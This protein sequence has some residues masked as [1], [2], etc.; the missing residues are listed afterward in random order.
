MSGIALIPFSTR[1]GDEIGGHIARGL[2]L[3]LSDWLAT[4][5]AEPMVLN[6]AQTEE[7][8]AWRKLV[9][10]SD[11]LTTENVVEFMSDIRGED[12]E[13]PDFRTVISGVIEAIADS[14]LSSG[15]HVAIS[16]TDLAGAFLRGRFACDLM[17]AS[18]GNSIVR[19]FNDVAESLDVK[20]PA[21]YDPL[22]RHIES[23]LNVIVT[24][25][26]T[27]AAEVGAVSRDAEGVYA[28][29]LEALRLDPEFK[30]ARDRLAELTQV[31]VLE[32][33][34]EAT[35]AIKALETAIA[36]AGADWRS[37]RARGHLLLAGGEFGQ[38]AKAF[39]L[40]LSGRHEAPDKADRMQ[41][42]L[43]AG[44]AFNLADRHAEA[45]R[46]LS[47]AMQAENLRVDAIVE[48]AS[49]SASM[50]ETAVAE[51]LWNRAL[52]LEPQSI[53]A[54]LYL[55]RLY[56]SRGEMDEAANQYVEML[57]QPGLPREIF[58]DAAEFFVVNQMHEKALGAAEKY[59][60]EHPG[61]AIAHVLTAS[62]LNAL[63][64][65]KRALKALD[66]A[67]LCVGVDDFH[68]LMVRQ[69]RFAEHPEA[70]KRFRAWAEVCLTGSA[71][72]GEREIRAIIDKFE[73]FWEAHFFLGIALRRQDKFEEAR[74]VLEHLR[75]R[76]PLPGIEKELTGIY[77][78]L[79]EPQKALDYARQALDAAPED[80]TLLTNYAAALLENNE[81]DEANKFASR[82][83]MLMPDD[84]ATAKLSELIKLR[85]TKRGVIKNF[86]ATL[87]DATA[88]F[89]IARR[90]RDK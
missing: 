20:A 27:L 2:S 18:F 21:P 85:M 90:K 39:C 36:R 31:L 86:K 62:S 80:P 17:P 23:W 4:C 82:A 81:I 33:G 58:A 30:L 55:A 8:G 78:R 76:Q 15:L 22:T 37:Q 74:D 84:E 89:R 42:A 75:S 48:S 83:Q 7:D 57:K 69:R 34:F 6:S 88:W 41:A 32:R 79:G 68:D 64:R 59:A 16:V 56:R 46:V 53:Q 1:S 61:D 19:L 10:F 3:E 13:G 40:V 72:Q 24:R 71:K 73:D 38:A 63:G 52:E 60:E 51:R 11:E 45:Q 65:H 25:A 5:S 43:Q 44:R 77:S 49:S 12:G 29:A 66:R 28:P 87:K 14:P 54:R 47:V 67:E 50:G 70:E 35:P 26:L 9:S